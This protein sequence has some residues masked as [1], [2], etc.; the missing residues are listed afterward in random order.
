MWLVLD[1]GQEQQK[2]HIW[3]K[4]RI[5]AAPSA[6]VMKHGPV[7]SPHLQPT[8]LITHAAVQRLDI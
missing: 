5:F 8:V 2:T 3:D 1:R 4:D 7:V 6:W